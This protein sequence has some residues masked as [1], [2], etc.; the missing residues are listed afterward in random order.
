MAG[1][2]SFLSSSFLNST[3]KEKLSENESD[4]VSRCM[5]SFRTADC[6]KSWFTLRFSA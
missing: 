1:N 6:T 3:V 2:S 4:I 5:S